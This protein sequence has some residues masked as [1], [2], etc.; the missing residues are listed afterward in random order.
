MTAAGTIGNDQN[1]CGAFDPTTINSLTLPTGGQG[2]LE[3]VWLMSDT[4]VP[5]TS[6]NPHW[7][8]IPGAT[9]DSYDPGMLTETTYFIRCARRSGCSEYVG[10]SNVV[11]IAVNGSPT[12][13]LTPSNPSCPTT[14]D[15]TTTCSIAPWKASSHA[16]W[17]KS[18]PGASDPKYVFA[19]NSGKL[20]QFPNGTARITGIL[21]NTTDTSSKWSVD[22]HFSNG[23]NWTSWSALG[24]LYKDEHN[25]VGNHYLDWTYYVMDTSKTN[26]FTGLGSNAGEVLLL[27]HRP[28]NLKYGL[29]VGMA[30]NSKDADYGFSCWFDYSSIN[31]S[32]SGIGD[33]NADISCS[34]APAFNGTITAQASSGQSPYTFIWSNGSTGSTL[35]NAAAGSYSVT[36]TDANGC[37]SQQS[38]TLTLPTCCNV[39]AAGTISGNQ[40]NCG[41]FDPSSINNVALPTGGLGSLEYVWLK[42]DT[43]V[44]NTQGNPHWKMIAGSNSASYDPGMLTETTY[45]IRCARR[46]GCSFYAG[47]SNVITIAVNDIP[48]LSLV[49]IDLSCTAPNGGGIIPKVTGGTEPFTYNWSTGDS[50]STLTG[51]SAG[52]YS[53]TITDANG[54]SASD[55]LSLTLP[56]C[57]N[58]TDAG[59]ISGAQ[60]NCGPF[61]PDTIISSVLPSGGLGSLE[62][63]WLKSDTLV[64]NTQ[65][66]PHWTMIP[67]SNGASY[68][69]GMLTETTYFIRCVRRSGCSFYAGESNVITIAVNDIPS[70]SLASNNVSCVAPNGGSIT[71]SI[72]GG[73]APF[74]YAWS[75]GD[76]SSTLSGLSEGTYSLTITDSN[77]CSA[78]DSVSLSLPTCC[79]VTAAGTISGDQSNCGPFDP[80]SINSATLPSGGLGA[81]EYVW[82]KSD[83]LVPNTQG[84]PHWTMIPG[85]NSASYDPGMLTETTYFIR[86]AR[87]SGCSFYAGESNVIT[88]A[89]ND[90]PSVSLASN[91]VSC[92]APNG[93]SITPSISGGTA[94]FTYAWSTGDTSSTLS[95]LTEGAYSLTITDANGCSASD[96]VSLS[97]PTCCNVTAAGTISGDQSNC[98]PFD[99]TSINNATLPSGGLGSLE[100]VWLKSDTLVPNTSGNPHWKMIPGSNSAGYDPGMLTET[101][102]FIRCARRSGCSFYAGESNVITISVNDIPSVSLASNNVSCVAPNGGSITPSISGGTAPFTYAWSNGDSSSTLSGLSEGLYS[103]T[104]TDANGC[105]ASDSVSLS[106]PACCNVTAAGTISGDQSNCG[107]FDPS[108]ISSATLPSGGLGSLEYVW[109]KSDTLVPNTSGNPHWTMIPGSNSASYD[110]GMLTETTYFI[111]CARRSGCS[112]YAGES[113]VITISVNDIPS[114]SLASNNV[115]CVAPNGG[116]ITPSISGGSAPFTYA[117]STGDTS[118]TLSGLSEGAYSLTITDVNGCSASDSISLSLPTCCNVTAAGTISGNQSNCGPFD[119]TSINS[120]TLPSGGLGSLEYVWLKSDT[121]VPNTQGNPHWTM[122][123]GSNSASYDPG[124][125]TETTYFIRCARRSG[126]SIYAGES[127]IVTIE[128][129]SVPSVQLSLTN[130]NCQ[131]TLAG[132]ATGIVTG[133]TAPIHYQWSD[134]QT[135]ENAQQLAGG[136]YSVTVSDANGCFSIDTFSLARPACCNV[137]AAGNIGNDQDNCGPFDPMT[138]QSRSLPSGGVG[139]LEFVWLVSDTLVPNTQGNPYWKMIPGANGASYNPGFITQSKYYIRC[140][141]RSGCSFYAGESNVVSMIVNSQLT[142]SLNV[143]NVSC[144]QPTGGEIEV[145]TTTGQAPFQYNWSH[146]AS[147]KKVTGLR[148]GHYTVT[149]TDANGCTTMDSASL[150]LPSCC[151]VTAAGKI[152]NNQSNCGP[153]DP[154]AI[155]N[156]TLPTGGVGSLQYVWLMSDTLVANTTGNPY[157]KVVPGANNSSYDPGMLTETTYFIRCAR[158]SGCSVYAGESNVITIEVNDVPSL[159]LQSTNVDCANPNGGSVTASV[160]GGTAPFSYN[161]STGST[162]STLSGLSAG[163]YALTITDAKGCTTSRSVTLSLPGCCNVTAAGSI[164]SDQNNCGPFDP[165]PITNITL[166]SGGIGAIEYVWLKSDTNVVNRPGSPYWKVIPG[167]H[168]AS[169]DPGMLNETTYFIRCARRS[170]CSVYAGESNVVTITVTGTPSVSINCPSDISVA[171]NG[172][173][174]GAYVNWTDPQVTSYDPCSPGCPTSTQISGFIYLGEF[175]GHRYYCSKRCDYTWDQAN[176]L[177]QSSGGYLASINSLGENSFLANKLMANDAWIGYTDKQQEGS[178]IWINGDQNVFTRWKSG[179]PNDRGGQYCVSSHYGSGAD[180]TVLRP[181]GY[182]YDR[183][184]CSQY[185]FIMEVPCANTVSLTQVSGPSSGSLF[186]AGSTTITYVATDVQSGASDTCSFDV[187]VGSCPTVNYCNSEGLNSSHKW[188]DRVKLHSSF[189]YHSGN[190]GGYGDHTHIIGQLSTGQT[191]KMDLTPGYASTIYKLY[192]KVWIDWNQ[193][194]DFGDANERVFYDYGKYTRTACFHVPTHAKAGTTRMRVSLKYGSYPSCCEQF[195]YGEVEDYTIQVTQSTATRGTANEENSLSI[196]PS[197]GDLIFEEPATENSLL[198]L[199]LYPNPYMGEGALNIELDANF[200]SET[201]LQVVNAQ[202]KVV[203]ETRIGVEFGLNTLELHPENLSPGL[204]LIKADGLAE[205]ITFIYGQ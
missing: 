70:V 18:L 91:N 156:V 102:Y 79:N 192:W 66:N 163:T 94:P 196:A 161:W 73:S 47:E 193:D 5:N 35:S 83:T 107:P 142:V 164:G 19:N 175:N 146:G 128:V 45:F 6:G 82:L 147:T 180:Y 178:F 183:G 29:Q 50:S 26:A 203:Y 104:I 77:G 129:F 92:V 43:L 57:C 93:G 78:S 58:V 95:G 194:G 12:L 177:A 11:T 38:A 76:T 189:D 166:P 37:S 138:I 143:T 126:C 111:R 195:S 3:Y 17:I 49:T 114:V 84:N 31:G 202:G 160:T 33:F 60:S 64:P 149:V 101:T 162:S 131:D 132:A 10:E 133:G 204:Y 22:V 159:S 40:S 171:C 21:V 187:T 199:R 98:G 59:S 61:D 87:R 48:T 109:L 155:T 120:A 188:I 36:V 4:L 88:I 139:S 179:E 25:K 90:I 108:M 182:W 63:V 169:Y 96:S 157:W 97:L 46:S 165:A 34:S 30:A 130:P 145:V 172:A 56:S 20:Q 127:N 23:M 117:W 158:R 121:L 198:V 148:P 80:T 24:R 99:P 86:C 103:L 85:S 191:A 113:N 176:S 115:S 100:Y 135:S 54:C 201:D 74:T 167:A 151:N 42:S 140:A 150:S 9:G 181:N 106:L 1:N 65:G 28:S 184:G 7:K 81:L 123:P 144:A 89:V 44:P 119:P 153:F 173:H 62:Y 53:L 110:P 67:G 137:T 197:G 154:S 152:G 16:G 170:G 69:P 13:T 136:S 125:L 186:P 14:A 168:S 122:I 200:E 190:N 52:G 15:S 39:T 72:S 141:R 2:S 118:S 75:S 124:M 51:L 134:G 174:Q 105:S 71:P 27:T 112:F 68:D 185:E 41:P 55:S 32:Y 116:S 205:P 8:I